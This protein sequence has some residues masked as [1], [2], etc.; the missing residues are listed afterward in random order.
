MS[1]IEESGGVFDLIT[2]GDNNEEVDCTHTGLDLEITYKYYEKVPV[3]KK[4]TVQELKQNLQFIKNGFSYSLSTRSHASGVLI[5]NY[6]AHTVSGFVAATSC[7]IGFCVT[8]FCLRTNLYFFHVVL[9]LQLFFLGPIL[10]YFTVK[11]QKIGGF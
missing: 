7:G 4:E 11:S 9:F 5:M 1:D 8:G 10:T 2:F 6:K 3:D